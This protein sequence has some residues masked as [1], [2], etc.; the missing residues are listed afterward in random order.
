[1]MMDNLRDVLMAYQFERARLM[2]II[3]I[4]TLILSFLWLLCCRL[5]K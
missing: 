2:V 3:D 1:M 5:A 4:V